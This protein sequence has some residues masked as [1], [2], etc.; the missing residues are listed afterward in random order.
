M[1]TAVCQA[2]TILGVRAELLSELLMLIDT[3]SG[4]AAPRSSRFLSAEER[5]VMMGQ[6]MDEYNRKF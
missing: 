1:T 5:E 2:A 3:T 6:L 4:P